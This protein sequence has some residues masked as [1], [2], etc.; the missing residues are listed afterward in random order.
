MVKRLVN[1]VLSD[2]EVKPTHPV[3]VFDIDDTVLTHHGGRNTRRLHGYNLYRW[4]LAKE[5]PRVEIV[6]ITA[7]HDSKDGEARRE[8]A[9]DLESVGCS[10]YSKLLL[11]PPGVRTDD[12][13]SRW[14]HQARESV[15]R[16]GERLLL[17]VGDNWW[18]CTMDARG[19]GKRLARTADPSK[20]W[21]GNCSSQSWVSLKLPRL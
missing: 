17:T 15:R 5:R 8:A 16:G 10:Q 2:S 21:V 12:G 13:V 1:G 9:A 3:C 19:A 11:M 7:R 4:L 14:K 20:Y 6:F 18:D